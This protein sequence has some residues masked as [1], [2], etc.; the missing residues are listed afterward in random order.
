MD[1]STANT[2][3]IGTANLHYY[4]SIVLIS[5]PVVNDGDS[6]RPN[7]P[8]APNGAQQRDLSI[9]RTHAS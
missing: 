9:G 4:I 1:P 6:T 5:S 3:P 7:A 8:R 2:S